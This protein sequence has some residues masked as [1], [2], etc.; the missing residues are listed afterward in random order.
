MPNANSSYDM[1]V[2]LV[3]A[4]MSV[5]KFRPDPIPEDTI[6]KILEVARWAMSGANSQPWE[7]VVVTDPEI[8]KQLRDAYSEYNTDF[9]FWT[10]QEREY[11]LRHPSYQVKSD[12]H[13]S[14]RCNKTT[15]NWH[16]VP[17][18]I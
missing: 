4:R 7:F 5:R 11:N 13:Q 16:Q 2:K 9:I 3:K 1:L 17:S 12:R 10:E 15:A 14:L 6:N 8:K 18:V